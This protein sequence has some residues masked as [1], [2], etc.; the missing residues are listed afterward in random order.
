MRITGGSSKGRLLLSEK[1]VDIRPTSSKVREAV[2]NI[3]GNDLSGMNVLDLFAG[4]GIMGLEALS[5]KA[6]FSLFVDNSDRAIRLINKNIAACGLSDSGFT[7]KKNLKEDFPSHD[8]LSKGNIDLVFIDPPYG[9]NLIPGVLEAVSLKGIMS[10]DSICVTE[11]MKDDELPE[12]S[13]DLRLIK[14][15]IYGETKI[16]LYGKEK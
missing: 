16:V 11:S 8:L 2:F 13:G 1:G 6:A 14:S 15:R 4:T 3:I 10:R 7:I 12:L 5:R 9:K